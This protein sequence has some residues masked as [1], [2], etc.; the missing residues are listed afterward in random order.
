MELTYRQLP[1]V[2]DFFNL[3]ITDVVGTARIEWL[4][5]GKL[6]NTTFCKARFCY[7][8]MYIESQFG[9]KELH[10][11][12]TDEVGTTE[13]RIW[14]IDPMIERDNSDLSGPEKF[15]T[16]WDM[17]HRTD[18]IGY[19]ASNG[20]EVTLKNTGTKANPGP[21]NIKINGNERG[22]IGT[23]GHFSAVP[24]ISDEISVVIRLLR[25]LDQ[26]PREV[27]KKSGDATGVC[28]IC[29]REL[30]NPESIMRGIGPVCATKIFGW[31]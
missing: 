27:L 23:D 29:G 22:T 2:G 3:S 24:D 11:I 17:M 6:V 14:I 1:K 16:I 30:T 18:R 13:I 5:D 10:I 12:G 15:P 9:G 19:Q 26:H 7:H 8:Q 25:D 28:A 31:G 20:A 4:I 21:I